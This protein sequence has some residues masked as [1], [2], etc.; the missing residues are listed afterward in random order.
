[1]QSELH[2][3][4]FKEHLHKV[5][6]YLA[7][8]LC[9]LLTRV[10]HLSR[11]LVS[12]ESVF[13][14]P[15]RFFFEGRGFFF[16]WGEFD[17]QAL[18]FHKPP[19]LSL[20][21]GAMSFIGHDA[22]AGAKL[23]PFIVGFFVCLLPIYVT[24][25]PVP[26]ILVLASP[27]FYGAASHIQTDPTV[28]L[29]GYCLVCWGM[30]KLWADSSSRGKGAKGHWL[31]GCG[32]IILWCGKLEIAVLASLAIIVFW[33]LLP[34]TKA[35]SSVTYF[36]IFSIISIGLFVTVTWILGLTVNRSFQESVGGVIGTIVRIVTGK[37]Q[38]NIVSEGFDSTSRHVLLSYAN[39][40]KVTHLAALCLIPSIFILIWKGKMLK[41]GPYL[42]LMAAAAIPA[43]VYFTVSYTGDGYPR[44][45]LII[46][47]PLF[48][49][50]G[51][52]LQE[53]SRPLRTIL[54]FAISLVGVAVMLPQTLIA[55][56]SPG[57]PTA[58]KGNYGYR[59]AATVARALT[60]S[61]DLVMGPEAAMFY[62]Q[63]RRYFVLES[64]APY[65]ER[66]YRALSAA[67][68]VK[69]AI[70][71]SKLTEFGNEDIVGKIV[72]TM[73]SNGASVFRVGS[74]DVIV[75]T[76]RSLRESGAGNGMLNE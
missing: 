24:R 15:G 75:R 52:C 13:L 33:L 26:S 16:N 41:R 8:S 30:V 6:F 1:M 68:E 67:S 11:E 66:H 74:F 3:I 32:I 19:L 37:I 40:F 72:E 71:A 5:F 59:E 28:G 60:M 21:V 14:M 39:N 76:G 38:T 53:V 48:L 17:P 35:L 43:V 10:G 18:A 58:F 36:A 22:V 50:L 12:E 73:K 46:F 45:F 20:L 55:I 56:N 65:P 61:G 57:S 27:F 31:I 49:L 63:D 29:L 44:Y 54:S 2:G 62:L 47:P 34:K 51:L 64:F 4:Q 70:V 25:S 23:V 9:Y 42:F 7:I 69:A